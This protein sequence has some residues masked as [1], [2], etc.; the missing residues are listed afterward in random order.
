[1]SVH[2]YSKMSLLTAY[3]SKHDFDITC[4]SETYVTSAKDIN[5]ENLKIAKYIIYRVDHPSD[6]KRDGV[7][8]YCKTIL[9]LKVL[10]TNFLQE[11]INFEVSIGNKKCY[12]IH[13]NR[14]PSQSQDEFHDFLRNLEMNR[15]DSF[16]CNPFLT[17]VIGDVNAESKK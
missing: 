12:F 9:P 5:D 7:C 3:I 14:I 16:N 17:T 11:F 8:I 2:N 10:S 13:F 15:D 1:M 6:V 4:L